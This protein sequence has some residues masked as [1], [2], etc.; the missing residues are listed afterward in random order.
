MPDQVLAIL[1]DLFADIKR[2][3]ALPPQLFSDI[4]AT[5]PKKRGGVRAVAI[6]TYLY[7]LLMEPPRGI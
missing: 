7:R 3:A 1:G 5:L 2:D 6:A 4:M